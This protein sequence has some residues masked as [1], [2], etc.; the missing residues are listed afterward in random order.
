MWPGLP[1]KHLAINII[2]CFYKIANLIWGLGFTDEP[3]YS[4]IEYYL[5]KLITTTGNQV[6]FIFD[7][8]NPE[9]L[10]RGRTNT[11]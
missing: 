6:D 3:N 1:S 8:N 5:I 4:L 10:R 2:E 9:E 11:N 7:W